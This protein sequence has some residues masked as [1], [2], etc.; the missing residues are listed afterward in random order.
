MKI[1]SFL[2]NIQ[3][4]YFFLFIVACICSNL[5]EIPGLSLLLI[6]VWMQAANVLNLRN[7]PLTKQSQIFYVK[8]FL[9]CVPIILIMGSVNAF[10]P[11]FWKNA[12]IVKLLCINIVQLIGAF[13]IC[14]FMVFNFSFNEDQQTVSSTILKV[15]VN[16]KSNLMPILHMTLVF[17]GL[18]FLTVLFTSNEY[19]FVALYA[20]IHLYWIQW[21]RKKPVVV[22]PA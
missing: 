14:S 10:F 11:V 13:L 21:I 16:M 6:G 8:Y 18:N 22:N 9:A 12:E 5:A 17:W 19:F 20:I 2:K 4:R 3:I 7:R 15:L 1:T